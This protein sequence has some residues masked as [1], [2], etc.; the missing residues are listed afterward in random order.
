MIYRFFILVSYLAL[1]SVPAMS[2]DCR[3]NLYHPNVL[4]S[5]MVSCLSGQYE[6]KDS[7]GTNHTLGKH[8]DLFVKV[9]YEN[10]W[11]RSQNGEWN[12]FSSF[13][14]TGDNP[15]AIFRIKPVSPLFD[16]REYYGNLEINV[17][18]NSIQLIN[19]IDL[20]RYIMGVVETEAGPMAPL[21]FYKVQAI[22]G[23]TYAIRNIGKHEEEGYHLC[24]DTH[25]QAYK[26]RNRWNEELEIAVEVTNGLILTDMDSIPVMAVFHSN[27]G[28]ET[29]SPEQ[30]WLV[31]QPYL[32]PILDPFSTDMPHAAWS[33]E[34]PPE[35]WMRY[36]QNKG[37]TIENDLSPENFVAQQLHREKYY[38][39]GGDS[40]LYSTI[41]KDWELNSSFFSVLCPDGCFI[42]DGKGYGHGVGMSQE[43]AIN[44]A[45]KGYHYTQILQYYFHNVLIINHLMI[46][47]LIEPYPE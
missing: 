44:M 23:R 3:I 38:H 36:L 40:L 41:R 45:R 28:G 33:R 17:V 46:P 15:N 16:S 11:V 20:E 35:D 32:K 21:E 22:I 6:F 4:N 19:I 7:R 30:I 13:T 26:G 31:N 42:L 10:L 2:F 12:E 14:L 29:G 25:C 37:F 24:D 8:E 9:G 18:F 47:D 27:S 43:G 5:V 34:I 1:L 39:A